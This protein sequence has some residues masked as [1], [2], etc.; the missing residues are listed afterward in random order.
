MTVKKETEEERKKRVAREIEENV[1]RVREKQEAEERHRRSVEQG[2]TPAQIRQWKKEEPYKPHGTFGQTV[3][4]KAVAGI[5][6]GASA[7][8]NE[9][10]KAPTP[11]KRGTARTP[12]IR[13]QAPGRQLGYFIPARQKKKPAKPAQQKPY[14]ALS[15]TGAGLGSFG[16]G[17]RRASELD[18]FT[19]S[20]GKRKKGGGGLLL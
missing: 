3:K 10:M 14:G 4:E 6:A 8:I 20:R 19:P 5:K 1:R 16:G 15:F 2:T 7:G 12:R 18:F 11:R 9:L 17:G 13:T